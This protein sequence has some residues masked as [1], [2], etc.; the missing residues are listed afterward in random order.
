VHPRLGIS[1]ASLA[2]RV[3]NPHAVRPWQP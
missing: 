1:I 2:D 3:R